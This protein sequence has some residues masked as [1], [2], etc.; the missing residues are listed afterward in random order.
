[1]TYGRAAEIPK[2]L[3]GPLPCDLHEIEIGTWPVD[4]LGSGSVIAAVHSV[5]PV[6]S[7]PP[8]VM[9]VPLPL[10]FARSYSWALGF[11][12]PPKSM[13]AVTPTMQSPVLE[14]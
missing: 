2:H 3:A 1:M 7:G 6:G 11:R 8:E 12:F 14:K 9:A 13:V 5:S 4:V 10:Q